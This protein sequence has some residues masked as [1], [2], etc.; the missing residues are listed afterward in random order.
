MPAWLETATRWLRRRRAI[1][2]LRQFLFRLIYERRL[3]LET[4]EYVRLED[5]GLAGEG[6]VW[7]EPS[8]WSVLG[9]VLPR[10]EV[11]PDDVFIDLGSGKGR[12][13]LLAAR[14]PFKR[15]IGVELSERLTE[16]AR[17]N[18]ERNR[19]R[20]AC[21]DIELVTADALDYELPDDVTVAYLFNPFTGETFDRVLRKLIDSVDRNPRTLRLIYLL[22]REHERIM[23]TGRARLVKGTPEP[24]ATT[25]PNTVMY[26]IEP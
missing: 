12:V 26:V 22:P 14:Y 20:L 3:R 5:L 16:I 6:R 8:G 15:V 17:G 11:S 4:D 2:W 13:V 1:G 19:H 7:Y 9:H 10:G 23:R 18:L 21:Q 24:G 25:N